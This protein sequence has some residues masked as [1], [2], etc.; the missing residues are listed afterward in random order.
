MF[1]LILVIGTVVDNAICVVECCVRLIHEEKMPPR[2]AAFRTMRELTG[3]LIASTLV[4]VAIY[5]PIAFYG[6]MVGIIYQQFAITMCAAICL[7][8]L[9]SLTLSPA[10]CALVLKDSVEPRGLFKVFNNGLDF[11]RN[12]YLNVS[13]FLSRFP[14]VTLLILAVLI[15]GNYG[16]SQIL[17]SSFMPAEDKGKLFGEVVLP[18]GASVIRTQEVLDQY[19]A[20][21]MEVKGL[22]K[23]VSIPGRSLTAGSGENV[24][25]LIVNLQDWSKRKTAEMSVTKI[26]E[27]LIKRGMTVAEASVKVFPAPPISGLGSTGGVS[28][29]LQATGNQTPQELF[30]TANGLV[31][32]IQATGKVLFASSSFDAN[33]PMLHLEVDRDKAEAMDI[34]VNSIFN[35]LQSQ[36]GSLYVNDFNRYGKTYKVTIQADNEFRNNINYVGQLTVPSRKGVLVPIDAIAS[37]KWTVG[38]RFV[39]RFNMFPCANIRVQSLPGVSS[40]EMMTTIQKI[41]DAE[42]PQDYRLSWTDMSYQESRNEGQIIVMIILAII[43]AYLFLVAQYESWTT[44][45]SVMLSVVAATAGGMFALYVLGRSSDIYCQLGLLMLIGLTAKTA[46]LM[47]EYSKRLRDSGMNLYDAAIAG[48]RIRF[49]AVMM[50]ALSFAAGVLP[51]VAATGAGAGGRRSIGM[52]TF[53]GMVAATVIGMILVPSLYIITRTISEKTKQIL[54]KKTTTIIPASIDNT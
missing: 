51:M 34:A 38:P 18:S 40:G 10:L 26:Q 31:G 5:T 41:V 52:T 20:M 29:A 54:F 24:G 7:S 28:F 46:I 39:E 19:V 33:A 6:G 50:T 30:Q 35:T 44:P 13:G 12:R 4:V 15:C 21:A 47:V 22:G 23:L 43:F 25:F 9:V 27:Q 53:W 8:G 14:L 45:I 49:R 37:V 36:L 32:K 11:T 17:P 42:I 3:A 48:M 2:D 16:L 1:A